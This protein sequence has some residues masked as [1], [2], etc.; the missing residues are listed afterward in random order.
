M[1]T[2]FLLKL[3]KNV[4]DA[5]KDKIVMEL[6]SGESNYIEKGEWEDD[7]MQTSFYDLGN[8]RLLIDT[9][10]PVI[11]PVGWK[12]GSL[13]NAQKSLLLNVQMI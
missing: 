4:S 3:N 5:V 8:V 2:R 6:S 12:N 9:I 1:L 10:A 7:F 13:F 11:V